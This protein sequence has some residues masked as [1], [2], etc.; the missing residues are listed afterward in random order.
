[1]N[2]KNIKKK[3]FSRWL[4][5]IIHIIR[6]EIWD[7]RSRHLK[8]FLGYDIN[9]LSIWPFMRHPWNPTRK[10][11]KPTFV[12]IVPNISFH[13][14]FS[15]SRV[16]VIYEWS[17]LQMYSSSSSSKPRPRLISISEAY[18]NLATLISQRDVPL[19]LS[20]NKDREVVSFIFTLEP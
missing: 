3:I 18:R 6:F 20:L 1:M 12:C 2:C 5:E 17:L 9:Y 13:I 19:K 10:A 7:L 4:F 14:F 11:S 8:N 16:H 15:I